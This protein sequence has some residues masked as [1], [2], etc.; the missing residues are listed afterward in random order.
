M[1]DERP[2]PDY[3]RPLVAAITGERLE[4]IDQLI[5][6]LKRVA[7]RPAVVSAGRRV[8]PLVTGTCG[9][10][11]GVSLA[12]WVDAMIRGGRAL[13]TISRNETVPYRLDPVALAGCVAAMAVIAFAIAGTACLR[14]FGI[15]VQTRGGHPAGRF[16]CALRA[17][18]VWLPIVPIIRVLGIRVTSGQLTFG[19]DTHGSGALTE[20]LFLA[21]AA[22]LL[23]SSV[24][25]LIRPERS[26]PDVIC[27]TH[28]VPR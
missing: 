13:E 22:C 8:G 11:L 27:G 5:A 1:L 3:A 18:I 10:V 25:A 24:Y 28:L 19:F 26:V 12:L 17:L 16:R 7:E 9:A 21:C 15:A 20:K 4:S 23:I 6:G 14:A 2:I